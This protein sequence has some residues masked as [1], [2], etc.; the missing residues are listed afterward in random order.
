MI[1]IAA[2]KSLYLNARPIQEAELATKV[3]EFLESKSEKIVLIKA[4][5]DVD[6]GTVMAAMDQLRTAGVEDIGLITEPRREPG[7][8]A[9][10]Q[11]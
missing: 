11:D 2:N 5:I 9:G 8:P 4:D 1:A 3:S 7:A 6:Y 10:G